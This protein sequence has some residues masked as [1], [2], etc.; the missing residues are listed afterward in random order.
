MT[1]NM[2]PYLLLLLLFIQLIVSNN[3]QVNG[4]P[5]EEI[6]VTIELDQKAVT[7]YVD[8]D[9]VA[10]VTFTGTVRTNYEITNY[11]DFIIITINGEAGDWVTSS[12]P[13]ISFGMG[14]DEVD[15]SI[16]VQVPKGT[17]SYDER[18]LT[19]SG[20]WEFSSGPQTGSSRELFLVDHRLLL[21]Y[22]KHLSELE[23]V[24]RTKIPVFFFNNVLCYSDTNII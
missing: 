23:D 17:S 3:S 20:T 11:H 4:D 1:R 12:P 22:P 13:D 19:V 5:E 6:D 7:A 10:L 14:M 9:Q 21:D 18:D 8:Y 15:F 2:I 24:R 16:T